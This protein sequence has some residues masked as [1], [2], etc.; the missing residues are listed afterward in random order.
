M[1]CHGADGGGMQMLGPPLVASEW[2]T[3]PKSRLAAILLQGMMGPIQVGGKNY[4]PAAAMPGLRLDAAVSDQNLADVATFVRFAW[5][6]KKG[7]VA[8][9]LFAK[10]RVQLK[11]R[12]TA[13]SDAELRHQFVK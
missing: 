8:P 11:D 1:A 13:F 2:T 5:D 12:D 10:M 6:N 3:G 9:E 4:T 7:S